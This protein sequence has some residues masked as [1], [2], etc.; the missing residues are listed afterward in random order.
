MW[1][2]C[3]CG[4]M[5]VVDC[6]FLGQLMLGYGFAKWWWVARCE[7]GEWLWWAVEGFFW[8]LTFVVDGDHDGGVDGGE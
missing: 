1:W 7:F 6:G 5:E 4:G 2:W 3:G 8:V